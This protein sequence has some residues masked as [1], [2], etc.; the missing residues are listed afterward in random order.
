MWLHNV[1]RHDFEHWVISNK[2]LKPQDSF[3][4]FNN[5][6]SWSSENVG[7]HQ[8]TPS[9]LPAIVLNDILQCNYYC[10]VANYHHVHNLWQSVRGDS[11][12]FTFW[13]FP[14]NGSILER[15]VNR[16]LTVHT[17]LYNFALTKKMWIFIFAMYQNSPLALTLSGAFTFFFW[18]FF[19]H[20]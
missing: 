1:K 14:E 13:L 3:G 10:P 9:D 16:A 18:D 19:H 6:N 12:H 7:N 5:K 4:E 11:E 17:T 8:K 20:L 15:I 2:N